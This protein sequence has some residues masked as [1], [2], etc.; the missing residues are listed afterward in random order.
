MERIL[1]VEDTPSLREGLETVLS[2]EGYAVASAG[3]AEEA[4]QILSSEEFSL[5]LSDLKLPG[6]SGIDFIRASKE[7]GTKAPIIVMTAYGSIEIAVEA[8]K[9]GATDFV[10]KPFDPQQ[11]CDIIAQVI[12]YRRIISRNFSSARRSGRR[13]VTKSPHMEQVLHECRRAASLN[14]TVLIL[15]E[16]GTGKELVAHYIHDSSPR[17]EK[18]F[19][20]VNCGSMPSELLESEF[21]G[22]V[23]GAFTG[24]TEQRIGL[25]EVANHG[26]IFLDEIGNMPSHLQ[27]KLLR[28]LQESEIKPVGS[29][30]LR[31]IDVRVISATNSDI[32][33]DIRSRTFREDLYYRLSV[34]VITVPPLRERKE[35]I[36][37]LAN[38]FV[39]RFSN[40]AGHQ[41]PEMTM[42]T[43]KLLQAYNWPG[44]VRELENAIER[45]LVFWEKGPLMPE[46]FELERKAG[47][48]WDASPRS[49]AEVSGEAQKIAEIAAISNALTL[50]LGNKSQAA[51]L[52]G[53]SY[54]TLLN[55]IKEYNL[56]PASEA[57]IH[58]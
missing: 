10:T 57:Q 8:M 28:A 23:A 9:L 26:S 37:L 47:K 4:L 1:V 38:Y 22:H 44:N 20:P 56:E 45:A 15:G 43:V 17:A 24:A 49:L 53:V 33:A 18:P 6:I 55:K 51:R 5:I 29:T 7:K 58:E 27:A 11:L 50:S 54:K 21:F 41:P 25:F 34:M 2:S 39:K 36:E 31:K 12:E 46:H 16:S 40:E 13:L 19:V 3:T 30:K 14:S 35:D 42:P 32:E 48:I 52:L